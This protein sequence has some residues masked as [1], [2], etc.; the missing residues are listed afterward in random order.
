MKAPPL[1]ALSNGATGFFNERNEWQCTGSQMG[2]RNTLPDTPEA[3]ALPCKLRLVRM[4]ET[5]RT[6]YDAG[7]A[8]WGEWSPSAGGMWRAIG[9]CGEVRAEVFTRAKSRA[10]AR[11]R[12]RELLP[13]A[14]FYR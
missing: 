6:A 7:G 12:V 4:R 8:Y 11:E 5:D 9:D 2:R 1:P 13:G 10:E 14:R 3:R